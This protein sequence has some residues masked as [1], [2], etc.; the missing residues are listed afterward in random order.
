MLFWHFIKTMSI[1]R[2][3]LIIHILFQMYNSN[4]LHAHF[5]DYK[6]WLLL[7]SV[8]FMRNLET[9]KKNRLEDKMI[10]QEHERS[11]LYRDYNWIDLLKS[12][13][14]SK[15]G[16]WQ[17]DKYLEHF[18][19]SNAKQFKKQWKFWFKQKHNVSNNIIEQNEVE[20]SQN[21][22][23]RKLSH[24]TSTQKKYIGV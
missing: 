12:G 3:L 23:S 9:N 6:S 22:V 8:I 10:I 16:V 1:M 2:P 15:L 18:M 24:F 17:F 14:L 13:S 7:A 19:L 4:C 5:L 20:A 21:Q 11:K